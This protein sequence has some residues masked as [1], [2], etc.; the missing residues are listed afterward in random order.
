MPAEPPTEIRPLTPLQQAKRWW[1]EHDTSGVRFEEILG[2]HLRYGYVYCGPDC[3]VLARPWRTDR[4][5][6]VQQVATECRDPD[7]WFVWL[8]AGRLGRFAALAPFDLP[9]IAWHHHG[10]LRVLDWQ[11][12]KQRS[13][14]Y[15]NHG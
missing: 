13:Q 7:C 10:R 2:A 5:G 1:L 14:A 8:A 11:K 9:H 3:F 15:G 6:R 4:L 12:F